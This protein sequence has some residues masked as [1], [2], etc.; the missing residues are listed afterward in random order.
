MNQVYLDKITLFLNRAI[1][2][3]FLKH[4]LRTSIGMLIG[5]FIDGLA[6]VFKPI[7]YEI[8][9]INIEN[10]KIYHYLSA[11]ILIVHFPTLI[12]YIFSKPTIDESVS[13]SIKLIKTSGFSKTEQK[14]YYRKLIEKVLQRVILNDD[15]KKQLGSTPKKM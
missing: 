7:I 5:L 8:D 4:P 1:D 15:I 2:I 9:W 10:I 11:G 12:S 13:E 6:I 14:L 3:L